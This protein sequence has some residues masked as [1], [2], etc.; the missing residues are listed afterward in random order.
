MKKTSLEK[1]LFKNDPNAKYSG[2]DVD[3]FLEQYK[4]YL[5]MLDKISDRRQL[6]NQFF[7]ALNT[8]LLGFLGYIQA[9]QGRSPMLFIVASLTGI[10]LSYFWHTL[11][12]SYR[13]LNAVKFKIILAIEQRLPIALF[14]TEWEIIEKGE[15]RASYLPLTYIEIRIPWV[16]A[17][18]YLVIF[19]SSLL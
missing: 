12:K 17:I 9:Q 5:G 8:A 11:I 14:D 10:C 16:F 3:Y 18:F 15:G 2:K 4:T 6:A 7:L 1:K 13:D 19:V